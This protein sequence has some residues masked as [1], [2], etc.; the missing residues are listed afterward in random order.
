MSQGR[1]RRRRVVAWR[2]RRGELAPQF[3]HFRELLPQSVGDALEFR[4]RRPERVGVAALRFRVAFRIRQR[5]GVA[6]PG[7]REALLG[8]ALGRREA[9]VGLALRRGHARVGVSSDGVRLTER[10]LGGAALVVRLGLGLAALVALALDVPSQVRGAVAG[11]GRL[12]GHAVQGLGRGRELGL[13][14][15]DGRRVGLARRGAAQQERVGLVELGLL[16]VEVP[17]Q[18]LGRRL[19]GGALLAQTPLAVLLQLVRCYFGRG[20]LLAQLLLERITSPLQDV[21]GRAE[22]VAVRDGPGELAP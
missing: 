17:S 12:D 19:A 18:F 14:A 7:V 9:R 10:L 8:L 16:R 22:V 4:V 13:E 5:F 2:P 20:A 11:V 21:D 15:G 3:S 6:A 1:R